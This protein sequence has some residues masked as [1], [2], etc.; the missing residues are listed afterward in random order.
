M[1]DRNL[2][3]LRV[4]VELEDQGG[5]KSLFQVS[6]ES[7]LAF[8]SSWHILNRLE[9]DRLVRVKRNRQGVALEIRSTKKGRRKGGRKGRLA[10]SSDAILAV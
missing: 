10:V 9:A 7:M 2:E 8:S 3:M 6:A 4:I 5:P 1:V